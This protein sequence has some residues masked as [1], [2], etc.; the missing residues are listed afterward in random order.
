MGTPIEAR[1][2]Q[3]ASRLA[4]VLQR[5]QVRVVF[6]ES[7]TAGLVAATLAHIPG[8]S[9]WLCGAAVTY[10]DATKQSW[11]GVDAADLVDPGAVSATVARQMA[12]GVLSKTPEASFA[13][14]VT[15]HLGP[16]APTA[17]DGVVFIGSAQ[18]Q[19]VPY[20]C[21]VQRHR[22]QTMPRAD[23]QCAATRLVMATALNDLQRTLAGSADSDH[24]TING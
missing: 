1:L 3:T 11:L 22:L 9:D 7:C 8:I 20:D 12:D 16:H 14:S 15:G 2:N 6:A 13:W 10:R 4:D 19:R 17:L 5:F 21:Q 18:R 23:R 24:H